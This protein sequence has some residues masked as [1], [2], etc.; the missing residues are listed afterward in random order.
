MCQLISY[1][2]TSVESWVPRVYSVEAI[3]L[4]SSAASKIEYK[5]AHLVAPVRYKLE[6]HRA[7]KTHIWNTNTQGTNSSIFDECTNT[8]NKVEELSATKDFAG[9]CHYY[10]RQ[11]HVLM[12]WKVLI[13]HQ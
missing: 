7:L 6:L 8:F 9:R 3:L 11:Y 13:I 5:Q 12:L 10:L 2:H 4:M 1:L